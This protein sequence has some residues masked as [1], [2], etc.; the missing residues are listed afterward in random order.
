MQT[1]RAAKGQAS[2]S[3]L[4][5][6]AAVVTVVFILFAAMSYYA[7]TMKNSIG[8]L[9]D[10]NNCLEQAAEHNA[11]GYGALRHFSYY[12][13]ESRLIANST[14]YIICGNW[15]EPVGISNG[16]NDWI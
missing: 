14:E 5:S 11:M 15:K 3:F 13:S 1:T 10:K 12:V 9:Y 2:L 6:F 7:Y 16:G 8:M 4:I